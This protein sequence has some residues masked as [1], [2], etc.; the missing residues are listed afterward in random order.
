[1]EIHFLFFYSDTDD[2]CDNDILNDLEKVKT[3]E[4]FNEIDFTISWLHQIHSP[5]NESIILTTMSHTANEENPFNFGEVWSKFKLEC[6]ET[7]VENGFVRKVITIFIY[8]L[9][10]LL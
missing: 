6:N 3:I 10:T 7:D 1:M 2:G 5:F 8:P 9:F 4:G